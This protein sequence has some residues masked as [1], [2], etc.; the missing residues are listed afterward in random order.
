MYQHKRSIE[1]G[2]QGMGKA[3]SNPACGSANLNCA[4]ATVS[5]KRRNGASKSGRFSTDVM[6]NRVYEIVA[7]A[8]PYKQTN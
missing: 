1:L 3:P 4:S 6:N 7:P 2:R 8:R 5:L